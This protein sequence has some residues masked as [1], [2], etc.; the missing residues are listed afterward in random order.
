M[1]LFQ[2]LLVAPAAL[3]LLAPMAVN[4]TELNLDGVSGYTMSRNQFKKTF[5]SFN[6][7]RPGDWTFEALTSL[8]KDHSCNASVPTGSITRYEAAALIN[9]CLGNVPEANLAERKLINEFSS[10]LAAINSK[11]G[12]FE[13]GSSLYEAGQFSPTTKISGSAA[14]TLGGIDKGGDAGEATHLV[15]AYGL[16]VDSSFSGEDLLHTEI[17]TGNC[18]TS[19]VV[20]DS[21]VSGSSSALSIA[22]LWYEFPYGD[23]FRV[24]VGPVVSQDDMLAG[25]TTI[26]NE[27]FALSSNPWSSGVNDESGAGAGIAYLKDGFNVTLNHLAIDSADPS[28]GGILTEGGQDITTVQLGYDGDSYGGALT[29][30]IGDKNYDASSFGIGAYWAPDNFPSVSVGVE[31]IDLDLAKVAWEAAYDDDELFDW[32]VGLQQDISNGTIGLGFG[33]NGEWSSGQH[34]GADH[35]EMAYELWYTY[36]LNDYVTITPGIYVKEGYGTTKDQTGF[37]IETSFSF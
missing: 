37:A 11:T 31:W 19:G 25:T 29:Y 2:R 34:G 30:A 20:L 3:G 23:D 8:V 24:W 33:S 7:I 27:S 28:T 10:E 12:E 17:E 36:N 5:N 21:C 13:T 32:F 16:E 15:Y 35:D 6:D 4:A 26:Y 14:F 1:K 18:S 22:K 9:K